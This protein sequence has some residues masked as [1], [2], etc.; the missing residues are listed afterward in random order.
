[1][2]T[3]RGWLKLVC[4]IAVLAAD[5]LKMGEKEVKAR[6]E[7][8]IDVLARRRAFAGEALSTAKLFTAKDV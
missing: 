4:A 1:M 6:C 3:A 7:I 2:I 8:K 5:R